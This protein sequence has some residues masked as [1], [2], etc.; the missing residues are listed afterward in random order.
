[1]HMRIW[2]LLGLML[3]AGSAEAQRTRQG[4]VFAD[5]GQV[6]SNFFKTKLAEDRINEMAV[7][8]AR[9]RAMLFDR[10]V[11]LQDEYKTLRDAAAEAASTLTDDQRTER[12]RTIDNRLLEIRQLEQRIEQF[13]ATE[14][15]KIE[16]QRNRLRQRIGEEIR[17]RIQGYA[18]A[19]GFAAV[20]DRSL[21]SRDDQP[22]LLFL[23]PNADVTDALVEEVNK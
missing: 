1:M 23:D 6:Y 21:L 8:Y 14:H 19:Q 4:V 10:F 17:E 9:E 20:L 11:A 15:K 5:F 18:R 12:R 2:L 16:D 22:G 3:W 13:D 7:S